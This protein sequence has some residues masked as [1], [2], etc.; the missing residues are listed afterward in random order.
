MGKARVWSVVM[1]IGAASGDAAWAQSCAEGPVCVEG[2]DFS[3]LYDAALYAQDY[4]FSLV[5]VMGDY[6]PSVEEPYDASPCVGLFLSDGLDL[7]LM[8]LSDAVRWPGI[9]VKGGAV[10]IT[11]GGFVGACDLSYPERVAE[12]DSSTSTTGVVL[13]TF[14][15]SGQLIAVES[16]VILDGVTFDYTAFWDEDDSLGALFFWDS[17]LEALGGTSFTAYPRQGALELVAHEADIYANLSEVTFRENEELALAM[18]LTLEAAMERLDAD[19]NPDEPRFDATLTEVVFEG[20]SPGYGVTADL[21]ANELASLT[22]TRGR[23]TGTG[24]GIALYALDTWVTMTD[25]DVDSYRRGLS[26]GAADGIITGAMD[27]SDDVG[28]DVVG[29]T[30]TNIHNSD[31]HGGA[32]TASSGPITLNGV[33]ASDLSSNNAP[34]VKAYYAPSLLIEDLTL[35]SFTVGGAPSAAIHAEQVDSVI[36]RRAAVCD[37]ESSTTD[38]G[39]GVALYVNGLGGPNQAVEVH[40]LSFWGGRFG[41]GTFPAAIYA[42]DVKYF[43]ARHNSVIGGDEP[44]SR[45][46]YGIK[47]VN[48]GRDRFD[49]TNNL[50]QG[51]TKGAFI[52]ELYT[53]SDGSATTGYNLYWDVDVPL[54]TTSTSYN[55]D[56]S[57]PNIAAPGFW[58][59]FDPED[60]AEPPRLGLGAYAIDKGDPAG[61]GDK[62]GSLADLGAF[63]GPYAEALPDDD[64]DGYALG[65]DCDDHDAT[66]HPQQTDLRLDGVDRNCDGEDAP[67]DE[68]FVDPRDTGADDTGADDT[69]ADDTGADDTSGGGDDSGPAPLSF[70]YF[71]GC[72]CRGGGGL[73]TGAAAGVV[74]VGALARRRRRGGPA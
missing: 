68:P 54:S 43:T 33:T 18:R 6:D 8:A 28:L 45:D 10:E 53:A 27:E 66:V 12:Y 37:G 47:L 44:T 20:N 1:F 52:N 19:G 62:D 3:T 22:I 36:L 56:T 32:I 4:G 74:L 51:L 2:V 15:T 38:A 72:A 9:K 31:D 14:V 11:G 17:D 48:S 63:G 50:I 21:T 71:G 42:E 70:D 41:E 39:G 26:V 60:C 65:L 61:L 64:G 5:E 24:D 7:H 73:D 58:S 35:T 25:T 69:G 23:H 67:Q 46:A 29:G 57:Y 40:N 55:L 59:L 16:S 34:L 13:R 49:V 30:F